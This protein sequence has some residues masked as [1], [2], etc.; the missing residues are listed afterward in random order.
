MTELKLLVL[1]VFASIQLHGSLCIITAFIFA[2]LNVLICL[3]LDVIV[4]VLYCTG[5]TSL[6]YYKSKTNCLV[7]S[8]LCSSVSHYLWKF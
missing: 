1:H 8:A 3:L 6:V 4:I 2:A 7:L 5:F